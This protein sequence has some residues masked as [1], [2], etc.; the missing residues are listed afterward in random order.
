MKQSK[1]LTNKDSTV[2]KVKNSR[3]LKIL[4][5]T[6]NLSDVR[7]FVRGVAEGCGFGEDDVQKI[8]LAA[9]EACT[10]II[11]HAY[12]FSPTGE[13]VLDSKCY[14]EKLS[15][16]ITDT[17]TPFNP[18]MV[19]V[20]DIQELAK[21]KKVGGLGIYLMKKLMDEVKYDIDRTKN[22]ITLVKYLNGK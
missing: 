5:R 16:I 1:N 21:K 20:P 13:I 6:D 3:R 7:K 9:D 8:V 10:N 11:K 19:P 2:S 12:K 15:L 4:S 22:Q 14:A 17:G 18:E